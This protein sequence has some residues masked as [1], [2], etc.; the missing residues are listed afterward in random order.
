MAPPMLLV[1]DEFGSGMSIKF[2]AE[3]EKFS[4]IAL[5]FHCKGGSKV[6]WKKERDTW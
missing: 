3:W 2:V 6:F 5:C 4:F 1:V